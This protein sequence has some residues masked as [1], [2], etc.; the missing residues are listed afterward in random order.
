MI[1][2]LKII[3]PNGD[4]IAY[5]FAFSEQ[6]TLQFAR[7]KI[8]ELEKIDLDYYKCEFCEPSENEY[9]VCPAADII[10]Y[11]TT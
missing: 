3:L 9:S 6:G 8:A 4:E 11:Y 2:K 1:E 7:L 5:N 10:S